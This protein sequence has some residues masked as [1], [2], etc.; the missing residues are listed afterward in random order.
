MRQYLIPVIATILTL[1]SVI[2]RFNVLPPPRLATAPA[3]TLGE[4]PGY[5]AEDEAADPKRIACLPSDTRVLRRRYL[6]STKHA[7]VVTAVI[8]GAQR[9]SIHRPEICLPV[10]GF[11]LVSER[12]TEIEGVNWRL[13]SLKNGEHAYE[14]AYTF[15]NQSGFQSASHASCIARDSFDR[16]FFRR[17]NRWVMLTVFV[18]ESNGHDLGA[19]LVQANSLI[20]ASSE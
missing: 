3:V 12:T 7:Y 5:A 8:G 16:A 18:P 6:D 4:F 11:T 9:R 14:F 13:I 19:F 20:S 1:I 2:L 10:Q 17:I 15:F